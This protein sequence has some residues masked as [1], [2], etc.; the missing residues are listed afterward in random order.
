[1]V[2][3]SITGYEFAIAFL[4]I[5]I[6]LISCAFLLILVTGMLMAICDKLGIKRNNNGTPFLCIL[7]SVIC[8]VMMT[9]IIVLMM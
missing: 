7:V 8:V 6:Y 1:M 2:I 5:I 4:S 9:I 3:S